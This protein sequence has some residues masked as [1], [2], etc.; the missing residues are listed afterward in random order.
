MSMN[1]AVT[2][3]NCCKAVYCMLP[4][5]I[6]YYPKYTS[7]EDREQ[8]VHTSSQPQPVTRIGWPASECKE[9]DVEFVNQMDV[10]TAGW[11]SAM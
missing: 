3:V 6:A 7:N 1:A 2:S 9:P 8:P 4:N 11:D 10:S 5:P